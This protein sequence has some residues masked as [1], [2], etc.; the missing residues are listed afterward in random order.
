[1]NLLHS[2]HFLQNI[3]SNLFFN[4][5]AFSVLSK[6]NILIDL[7]KRCFF[8]CLLKRQKF[9]KRERQRHSRVHSSNDLKQPCWTRL[10]SGALNGILDSHIAAWDWVLG[11]L[12]HSFSR[13]INRVLGQEWN[14]LNLIQQ[15]NVGRWIL[16]EWL[17]SLYQNLDP[18]HW[19]DDFTLVTILFQKFH[20]IHYKNQN[21]LFSNFSHLFFKMEFI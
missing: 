2:V 7:S 11:P 15:S 5:M 18:T 14:S 20:V 1:M 21:F 19:L 9:R 4:F 12:S 16:N 17:N 8:V 10:K 3:F 6:I 13:Y